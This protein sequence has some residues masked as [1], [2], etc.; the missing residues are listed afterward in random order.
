MKKNL[1]LLCILFLVTGCSV[2]YEIEIKDN[3]IIEGRTVTYSEKIENVYDYTLDLLVQNDDNGDRLSHDTKKVFS[4]G[5]TVKNYYKNIDEYKNTSLSYG[6][7][8]SDIKFDKDNKYIYLD[9]SGKF[10]CSQ[11]LNDDN[12]FTFSVRSNHKVLENNSDSKKGYTYSWNID[13]DNVEDVNIHIKLDSRKKVYNYDNSVF[14]RLGIV[15]LV[16]CVT[17]I[18]GFTGYKILGK[19]SENSDRI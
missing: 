11:Y 17:I 7:C 14:K 6:S 3:K 4:N 5:F 12:K 18:L 13:S 8:F 15:F 16:I 9:I 19:I 10:L 2:N 1:L